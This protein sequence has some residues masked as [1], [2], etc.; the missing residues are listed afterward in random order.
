MP[1]QQ[2]GLTTAH[3]CLQRGFVLV[4]N[5]PNSSGTIGAGMLQV[6]LLDGPWDLAINDQGSS[7]QVFVSNVLNGTVTRLNLAVTSAGVSLVSK[8]Q[9]GSGYAFGPNS[10]ALEV[11]PHRP[12]LRPAP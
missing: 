10:T 9:I 4:G 6:V 11:G 1:P 7:A 8:T 3:G 5:L 2:I 12:R